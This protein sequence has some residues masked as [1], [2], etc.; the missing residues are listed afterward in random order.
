MLVD[1]VAAVSSD[2]AGTTPSEAFSNA[3]AGFGS[4]FFMAASRCNLA[5]SRCWAKFEDISAKQIKTVNKSEKS[6][7]Y[8]KL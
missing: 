5:A 1:R 7:K 2:E 6:S 8:Q 3:H 4:I